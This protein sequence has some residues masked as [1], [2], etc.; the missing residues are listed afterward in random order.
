MLSNFNQS[1]NCHWIVPAWPAPLN[2]K[3]L[4]TVRE[5]GSSVEPYDS[6]NLAL[7]VGDDPQK[8][9]AN[10]AQLKLQANLPQEPLWL[11]QTHSARVV[12]VG[13]F[14]DPNNLNNPK[15]PIDADASV[16]F[17]PDQICAVLSADCLPILLC[18]KSGTRVSAIHAGWRGLAAGIVEAAMSKLD[19]DPATLLVWLGPAIGPTV[20]EVQADF[21]LAFKEYQ[22]EAT[23]KPKENGRWLA[24]IYQLARARL[25]KLGV[26]AIYGGE[27]CSYQD[28]ARFYS[29][30]RSGATGRMATLIWY[31]RP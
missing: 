18:N 30:R 5:G 3:A 14:I 31:H 20:Y 6:F 21:L 2:V 9:L 19:C 12:D 23:F 10:R 17:K 16:A 24:D 27:F 1:N 25:K 11:A 29:F 26:T 4:T 7:H 8:V 28:N 15:N 22:S 13:D